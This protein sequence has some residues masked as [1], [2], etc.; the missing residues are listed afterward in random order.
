MSTLA[1][2]LN[3][4]KQ[5]VAALDQAASQNVPATKMAEGV[6]I[7]VRLAS[8]LQDRANHKSYL[9]LVAADGQSDAD[10]AADAAEKEAEESDEANAKSANVKLS[11]DVYKTNA[12]LAEQILD[13]MSAVNDKIDQIVAAGKKGF[14]ADVARADIHAV[15]A[16]VAGIT[17]DVDL[18]VPWVHD[19]LQRLAARAS[20]L[21]SLFFPKNDD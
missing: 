5:H 11:Y 14:K 3:V 18:T 13:Q 21:H 20:H 4:L 1:A 2:D 12:K 8:Q 16:K 15:T 19:D 7:L 17:A 10:E 6:G 9:S